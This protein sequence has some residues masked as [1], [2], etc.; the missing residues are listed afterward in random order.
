MHAIGA[1]P[2]F[3]T[4]REEA[5]HGNLQLQLGN[6]LN[7]LSCRLLANPHVN[8]DGLTDSFQFEFVEDLQAGRVDNGISEVG[9]V[10]FA[11]VREIRI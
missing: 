5:D 8:N 11:F 3:R 9:G 7:R 6:K 1:I 4:R 2:E 10:G